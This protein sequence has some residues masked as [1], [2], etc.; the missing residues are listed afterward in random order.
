MECPPLVPGGTTTAS[1]FQTC[2]QEA[3]DLKSLLVTLREAQLPGNGKDLSSEVKMVIQ[4]M[5]IERKKII[6]E[7]FLYDE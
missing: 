2:S 5:E 1:L 3:N 4:E 7:P 6:G